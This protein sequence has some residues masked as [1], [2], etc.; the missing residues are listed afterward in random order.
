[1]L[2]KSESFNSNFIACIIEIAN[3]HSNH[4]QLDTKLISSACLNSLQQTL[5]IILIEEYLIQNEM[6]TSVISAPTAKRIKLSRGKNTDEINLWIE[7]AKL[8]RSISDYDSVKGIFTRN[9]NLMTDYTYKAFEH[10]ANYDFYNA[11]K[12]YEE[13]FEKDWGDNEPLEIEQELWEQSILRCC[14]ELTDWK[15]M[16]DFSMNSTDL[17]ELFTDSYTLE[18]VFPYAFKSKLKL[19]LQED[20]DEQRKHQDLLDFIKNIDNNNKQFLEQKYCLELALIYLHQK[21][22]H[23]AKYYAQLCIEQYLEV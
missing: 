9:M 1:M 4:F 8:Y 13:A 10:E 19:I 23:A 15:K 3:K 21:D 2:E 14:D 6:K 22:F 20:R 11:R 16:C 12:S 7:L 18:N 17:N 5:G